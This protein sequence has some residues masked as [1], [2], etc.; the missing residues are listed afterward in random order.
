MT[1]K[2]D[3]DAIIIGAGISGLVC[4]CYLAK[5]GLKTL[6][7]EMQSAPGGYCTSFRRKG[8][9]FDDCVYSLSSLKGTGSIS[10]ILNNLEMENDLKILRYDY[11]DIVISPTKKVFFHYNVERTIQQFQEQFPKQKAEI[12]KFFETIDN[13]SVLELTKIRRLTLE[14]VLN[15]CFNDD[16]L[17]TII[18]III[19]GYTGLP[20]YQISAFASFLLI[21]DYIFNGGYYPSGGMQQFSMAFAKKFE[22]FGGKIIYSKK[23]ENIKTGDNRVMGVFLENGHFVSSQIVVAACDMYQVYSDLITDKIK[24]FETLGRIK[25]MTPSLSAFLVYLGLSRKIEGSSELKSHVWLLRNNKN[26]IKKIYANILK[27]KYDYV[28]LTSSSIKNSIEKPMEK[29]SLFLFSNMPY[30]DEKILNDE[31]KENVANQLI[32][33]AKMYMANIE[34]LIAL[35]IVATPSTLRKWTMNY[36]GSAYGWADTVQQFGMPSCVQKSGFD[37]LFFTGHWLNRSSGVNV[38]AHSGYQTSKRIIG[39]LNK[40]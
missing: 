29:E 17:K 23:V 22:F 4:G 30:V 31:K 26:S 16:E 8:F 36:K 14:E 38:V 1:H 34:E 6:I 13:S 18:S 40:K 9:F 39:K 11:P 25:E 2:N 24:T 12:R 3:Y 32:D 33:I 15:Q 35:K 27:T 28:G 21:K 5:A 20:S 7:V 10:A 37:N 19:L